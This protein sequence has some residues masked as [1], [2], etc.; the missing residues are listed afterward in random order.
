M[1]SANIVEIFHSF[2]GEGFLAG[3][4]FL[5]VRFGGCNLSCKFCDTKKISKPSKICRVKAGP[6]HTFLSNPVT[7]DRFSGI[8]NSFKFSIV[9]F[10]G[11]EPLIH[12]GFIEEI[13]PLFK[14]R[15]TFIETNG[16]LYNAVTDRLIRE[17]DYWSADIKLLSTSKL[18]LLNDHRLFFKRIKDVKNLLIKCVFSPKSSIDEIRAAYDLALEVHSLNPR[19]TLTFQPLTVRNRI[20]LGINAGFIEQLALEG[21][22]DVR[23]IPQMHRILGIK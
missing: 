9:S 7:V 17:I 13:L 6:V 2:Q 16:T 8:L 1:E 3:K 4:P 11:G 19:T 10:T 20:K 12:A 22:M 5:F 21:R 14:G 18:D 15:E 23:L